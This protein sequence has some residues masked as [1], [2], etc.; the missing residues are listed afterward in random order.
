MSASSFIHPE[1]DLFAS[2]P[3]KNQLLSLG[4]DLLL[5]WDSASGELLQKIKL[6][7][8][9]DDGGGLLFAR[10]GH[11][12]AGTDRV[13]VV[14]L[15]TAKKLK[16]TFAV[17][18]VPVKSMELSADGDLLLV[19]TNGNYQAKQDAHVT[20]WSVASGEC[21]LRITD[22]TFVGAACFANGGILFHASGEDLL[23]LSREEFARLLEKK[24]CKW[25]KLNL[26][27]ATLPEDFTKFVDTEGNQAYDSFWRITTLRDGRFVGV[28]HRNVVL[29]SL[30][31]GEVVFEKR[32]KIDLPDQGLRFQNACVD[33]QTGRLLVLAVSR[34][35]D[36]KLSLVIDCDLQSGKCRAARALEGRS[37]GLLPDGRVAVAG[38]HRVIAL[39]ENYGPPGPV[40]GAFAERLRLLKE[41]LENHQKI[42]NFSL[43]MGEPADSKAIAKAM[44]ELDLPDDMAEFY[45]ELNGFTLSWES[46][47]KDFSGYVE[48][49]PVEKLEQLTLTEDR[50]GIVFSILR[51]Q[52]YD[53]AYYIP[54]QPDVGL[55]NYQALPSHSGFS[56]SLLSDFSSYLDAGIRWRFL[57]GWLGNIRLP[58]KAWIELIT[59]QFG[60]DALSAMQLSGWET[61]ET[62]L[63]KK[64]RDVSAIEIRD[65]CAWRKW[66]APVSTEQVGIKFVMESEA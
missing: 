14:D 20:V 10:E 65:L 16:H 5:V 17:G 66:E 46:D 39:D 18:D 30:Q 34:M 13:S 8:D 33:Q 45:G 9:S 26:P 60:F 38:N 12:I 50:T 41:D 27:T 19:V 57:V 49:V 55:G 15:A 23:I 11:A 61:W 24:N 42:Q 63:G 62:R 31:N 2:I 43:T 6:K 51:A 64:M 32:I 36:N 7:Y 58:G 3:E 54:G 4:G 47:S 48:I 53:V 1:V 29:F 28:S 22:T 44:K 59:K 56:N 40:R 35:H 25:Y 21:A 52:D 37:V